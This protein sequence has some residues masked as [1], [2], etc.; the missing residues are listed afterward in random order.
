[1]GNFLQSSPPWFYCLCVSD[2]GHWRPQHVCGGQ[3]TTC[4]ELVLSFSHV[5]PQIQLEVS[6]TFTQRAS[7]PA[8]CVLFLPGFCRELLLLQVRTSETQDEF[9]NKEKGKSY[10]VFAV[11]E[12]PVSDVYR[13][14]WP[15]IP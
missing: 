10:I 14:P 4:G 12:E 7:E 2:S 6:G 11:V 3:R 15:L 1:M 8:W 5:G 9:Y 13:F